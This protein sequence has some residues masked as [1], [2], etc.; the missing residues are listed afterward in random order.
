MDR[1]LGEVRLSDLMSPLFFAWH[2]TNECNLNCIHCLWESGP[3]AAW[4]E[5]LGEKEAMEVCRQII[6][7]QIP[8]VAFS[9]G[10]PLLY[11]AFWRVCEVLSK[12]NIV[13]KIESNG[14]LINDEAAIRLASFGL[15]SVQI[16]VDGASQEAYSKMRSGAKLEK[17]LNAIKRL[18]KQGV[19]T[20][21]V[22]VPAKFNNHETEAL[23]DMAVELGV[24]AFYTGKT[25]YI[26]RAVKSWDIIGL[27]EEENE[28]LVSRLGKKAEEY[29]DRMTILFYPYSVMDELEYRLKY[30]AAS[31]LLM[32]N[33]KVKLIGSM[34]F[35]CGDVRKHDLAEI[36]Q[37]YI[38]AW[39]HPEVIKYANQ[40]VKTPSLLAQA[41]DFVE[42]AL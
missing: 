36:W 7:L 37:R 40:A 15:R 39:E 23:I 24:K 4:P 16:S 5:E 6:D 9:G 21:I 34:P 3:N 18:I 14:H 26:G 38:R 42:L 1:N 22:Y 11:P 28:D 31:L 17:S 10:E 33:G 20:E 2:M 19:D 30:P 32:A 41:N 13:V 25:M 27:D 8:Y 29:R 12:K 35:V